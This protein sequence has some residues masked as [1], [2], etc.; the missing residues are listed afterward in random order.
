M[1][2]QVGKPFA[3]KKFLGAPDGATLLLDGSGFLLALH[4]SNPDEKETAL[5][6]KGAVE[7]AYCRQ[8]A[9]WLGLIRFR[10]EPSFSFDFPFDI[11]K[12]PGG[13]LQSALSAVC[14]TNLLLTVLIDTSDACVRSIRLVSMPDAFIDSL[15]EAC[16]LQA[17]WGP[18]F[19]A[20]Y[21]MWRNDLYHSYPTIDGLWQAACK[22]GNLG[23]APS[24]GGA[25]AAA[26]A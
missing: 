16:R 15:R 23:D 24:S 7:T 1:L 9:Y 10:D 6:A 26:G 3:D 13:D 22:S 18:H 14:G 8:D 12:H 4:I 5:C 2:L 19:P 11:T 25:P 20:V 17:S 21:S